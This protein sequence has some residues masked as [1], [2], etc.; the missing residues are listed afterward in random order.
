LDLK[1]LFLLYAVTL[2]KI[3]IESSG[4]AQAVFS[5]MQAIGLST[6]V[7][8]AALPL[9]IGLTTGISWAFAGIA[10]P[11]LVPYI[12]SGSGI[13]G[14]ALLLAYAS[15]MLGVMLSPL[16]PC[17]FLSAEYFKANLT[18][19][20]KYILPPAIAIETSAILIYYL[21]G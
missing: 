20:Y 12:A 2:Y 21:A 10:L 6:L 19:V 15:G 4:A 5:D 14:Y 13:N 8:L 7:M 11:L 16:H 3:T 17:F 9:L 1:I 18:K